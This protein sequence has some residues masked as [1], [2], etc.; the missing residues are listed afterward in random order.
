MTNILLY[1]PPPY[2]ISGGLGNFKLFFDI[3]KELGYSIY[4][5]PLLKNIPRLN[6]NT[7]FNN[8]FAIILINYRKLFFNSSNYLYFIE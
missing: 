4:Y 8:V 7:V 6:F 5:C 2:K 3:C 1:I